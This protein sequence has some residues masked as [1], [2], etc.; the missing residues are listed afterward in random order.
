MKRISLLCLPVVALM[1]SLNLL[2]CGSSGEGSFSKLLDTSF[3]AGGIVTTSIGTADDEVFALAIQPDGKLVTAGYSYDSMLGQNV[4]AMVR[5]NTDGSLDMTGFGSGGIVT[6]PIGTFD[7]EISSLKIQSDDKLVT[8]GFSYNDTLAQYVFALA[9]YN[10]NGSLDMT[11][12]PTGT[13]PGTV[14]TA[15]G[16]L[17]DEA[18]ALI[19]QSD[20]KLVAAGYTANTSGTQFKF[21]LARY[22]TDGTPD[23]TFNKTGKII[24]DVGGDDAAKALAIQSDDKL[25]AAGY[26]LQSIQYEFAL[27][28]YLSLP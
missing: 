13:N 11:F 1:V 27:V 8:A 19:I 16:T 10:T 21:A 6:T 18:N 26:S 23:T 4:F 28:R 9:R 25:V 14:T 3:G 15:F 2:S 12:N 7:D 22:N 5:Y 24:T 17:D 20:G